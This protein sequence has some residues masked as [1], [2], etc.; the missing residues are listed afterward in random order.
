MATGCLASM[1]SHLR[2]CLIV[3]SFDQPLVVGWVLY[4]NWFAGPHRMSQGSRGLFSVRKTG[5]DSRVRA[6]AS[7][8]TSPRALMLTP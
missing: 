8:Q 6:V 1:A 2:K 7:H 4:G 3:A 5:R